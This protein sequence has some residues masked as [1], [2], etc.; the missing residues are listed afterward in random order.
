MKGN[1]YKIDGEIAYLNLLKK[2]GTTIQAKIDAKDV[3]TVLEKG[4]WFARWHKDYNNFLVQTI[5][6]RYEG[7]KKYNEKITLQSFLLEV[8]TKAPVRHLN[9]D[10]LDNR[11]CNLEVYTQNIKN[12]FYE[13]DAQT[14]AI[15]LRDKY[16]KENGKA[17]VDKE[18]FDKVMTLQSC[19]VSHKINMQP[20]AVA[21]T[22]QGRI[23]LNR[24]I[25]QT[26]ENAY[27]HAINLNTLD[28]RKA[29]LE[30]I[31]LQEEDIEDITK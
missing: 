27:I 3:N 9:G 28:N 17:L 23:F 10:T 19:W 2:D 11:R 22:P 12:D 29:N 24:I 25:M 15:I 18:D 26:P 20:F 14:I 8:H 21:N 4:T 30:N 6:E 1:T 16:G 31:V 13:L 7:G 5:S